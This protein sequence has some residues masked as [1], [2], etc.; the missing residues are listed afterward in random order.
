MSRDPDYYELHRQEF[1]KALNHAKNEKKRR[2]L[3]KRAKSQ[4]EEAAD[5]KAMEQLERHK[6]KVAKIV[7]ERPYL[8]QTQGESTSI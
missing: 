4:E 1:F 2:P 6:A 7:I 8:E 5:R 3:R